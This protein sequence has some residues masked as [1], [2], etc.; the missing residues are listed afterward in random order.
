MISWTNMAFIFLNGESGR[1]GIIPTFK[2]EKL[3]PNFIRSRHRFTLRRIIIKTASDCNSSF[4]AV[5]SRPSSVLT[6]VSIRWTCKTYCKTDGI[7]T[8]AVCNFIQ[9]NHL[10]ST[11]PR[12]IFFIIRNIFHITKIKLKKSTLYGRYRLKTPIR[13]IKCLIVTSLVSFFFIIFVY[14]QMREYLTP[15]PLVSSIRVVRN[16][17][18][19]LFK[20]WRLSQLL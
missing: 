14:G 4:T 16:L 8:V 18:W 19:S 7:A 20:W 5:S 17:R 9:R 3:S 1:S 12:R 13:D 6:Q 11:R 10:Q 15:N 2:Y